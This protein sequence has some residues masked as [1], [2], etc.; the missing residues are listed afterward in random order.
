MFEKLAQWPIILVTGP[1][2]S[3]TTIAARMIEHDIGHKY[4]DEVSWQVWDGER[5]REMADAF[6]PCVLQG[7]GILK[8]A[9][10][11]YGPNCCVVLMRRNID[12]IIAS[13]KRVGWNRWAKKE[14]LFYAD[15]LHWTQEEAELYVA[16]TKYMYWRY[17]VRPSL[18]YWHEV[19]YESLSKHELWLPAEERKDFNARQYY[20]D[21]SS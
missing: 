3:G 5:A 7:P 18:S 13:Q 8:D 19:E 2:R 14:I 1:Q 9:R 21:Q 17:D 10:R 4:L 16:R 20:S 11:F 6:K 15:D 12:N